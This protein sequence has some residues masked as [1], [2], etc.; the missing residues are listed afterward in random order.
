[1]DNSGDLIGPFGRSFIGDFPTLGSILMLLSTFFLSA[2]FS[3]SVMSV[4]RVHL[5]GLPQP[6]SSQYPANVAVD[7]V[8]DSESGK[9]LLGHF[10]K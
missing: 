1:M 5:L 6:T 2:L 3:Y 8:L 7:W 9:F 10:S 4:Y